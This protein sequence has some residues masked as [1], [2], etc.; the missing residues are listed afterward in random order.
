M[1]VSRN[2]IKY[3]IDLNPKF[4][5]IKIKTNN[6][7]SVKEIYAIQNDDEMNLIWQNMLQNVQDITKFA[8]EHYN[9][10]KRTEE[11][12]REYRRIF[13]NNYYKNNLEYKL[14]KRNYTRERDTVITKLKKQ[15]KLLT[16][17]NEKIKQVI[18]NVSEIIKVN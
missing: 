12:I 11:E 1:F 18:N 4:S 9:R 10:K 17:E 16:E 14:Y 2:V 13:Y 6:S 5:F 15:N 3:L 8:N 7:V